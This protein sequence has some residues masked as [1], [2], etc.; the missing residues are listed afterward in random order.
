MEVLDKMYTEKDLL[1]KGGKFLVLTALETNIFCREK[2]SEE[3]RMIASSAEDFAR[4]CHGH[5]TYSQAFKEASKTMRRKMKA[6]NP[7]KGVYKNFPKFEVSYKNQPYIIDEYG[8][9][10]WLPKQLRKKI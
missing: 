9:V 10:W 4:I 3:Q 6:L 7:K 5:P 8:G 1:G 2:F